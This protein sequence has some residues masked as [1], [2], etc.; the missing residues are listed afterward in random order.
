MHNRLNTRHNRIQVT[1]STFFGNIGEVSGGGLLFGYGIYQVGG[2]SL[3]NT[4]IIANCQFEQN[5]GAVGG[6]IT[7]FGSREPQR[8]QP[9]NRFEIHNSSFINNGALYGSAIQINKE[10]FE[11][12]AVGITIYNS[13]Q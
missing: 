7:G 6:G 8:I 4:Y 11:S 12:I 3:F 2:Q 10:Y 5:Q 9:T 13:N 1:W